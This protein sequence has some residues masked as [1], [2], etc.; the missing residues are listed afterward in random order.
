MACL[1]SLRADYIIGSFFHKSIRNGSKQWITWRHLFF[2]GWDV[3][4][5][6][7]ALYWIFRYYRSCFIYVVCPKTS[8]V[9]NFLNDKWL[10]TWKSQKTISKA[11]HLSFLLLSL[12]EGKSDGCK[13][14]ESCTCKYVYQLISAISKTNMYR[15]P[16]CISRTFFHKI[17][18]KNQWCSLSMDT[19]VFGVL[20]NLVNIHKTSSCSPRV[21]SS[22]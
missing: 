8:W 10:W 18:A 9:C 2:T 3:D 13:Y 11:Q 17:E 5:T 16:P 12:N 7:L 14:F 6:K 4:P 21:L 15:K 19:S 22:D 20:K 1:L